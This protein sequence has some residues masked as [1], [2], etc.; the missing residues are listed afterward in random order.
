MASSSY[1][2]SSKNLNLPFKLAL[3]GCKRPLLTESKQRCVILFNDKSWDYFPADFNGSKA[4][5]LWSYASK[6]TSMAV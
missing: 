4:K 1:S 2:S 5:I 6:V 3:S